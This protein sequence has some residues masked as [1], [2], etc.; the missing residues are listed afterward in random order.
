SGQCSGL[1]ACKQLPRATFHPRHSQ[2]F[3]GETAPP[4][5]CGAGDCRPRNGARRG[6]PP[7]RNT[8]RCPPTRADATEFGPFPVSPFAPLL[9]FLFRPYFKV[10]LALTIIDP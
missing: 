4:P 8:R 9:A 6:R 7:C 1:P 10:A 3:P 2:S 5:G